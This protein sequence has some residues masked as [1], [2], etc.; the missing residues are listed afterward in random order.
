[1]SWSQISCTV[2]VQGTLNRHQNYIWKYSGPCSTTFAAFWTRG[3]SLH[4]FSCNWPNTHSIIPAILL[5]NLQDPY[6]NP[7]L[8]NLEILSSRRALLP[9][10]S[11]SCASVVMGSAATNQLIAKIDADVEAGRPGLGGPNLI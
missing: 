7:I 9:S 6:S 11:Q 10:S 4:K 5:K 1:M 8:R 2:M 3:G